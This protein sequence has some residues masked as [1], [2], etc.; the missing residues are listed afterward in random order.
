MQF[1]TV[2]NA[3]VSPNCRSVAVSDGER[4]YGGTQPVAA[5]LANDGWLLFAL[6]LFA[7]NE[8]G[9][10]RPNNGAHGMLSTTG[11]PFWNCQQNLRLAATRP[12]LRVL[13]LCTPK[14]RT[15]QNCKH[16]V[17][18]RSV[19]KTKA[20]RRIATNPR[21]A[22]K[23]ERPR[24][25]SNETWGSASGGTVWPTSAKVSKPTDPMFQHCLLPFPPFGSTR[26]VNTGHYVV[27][28]RKLALQRK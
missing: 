9:G 4:S 5:A 21:A 26:Y 27:S 17:L 18:G 11:N 14:H 22:Q 12:T 28:L 2:G 24:Q 15:A 25:T 8:K 1:P 6:P 20:A 13:Y 3:A 19:L 10:R 7:D 23:T 16:L